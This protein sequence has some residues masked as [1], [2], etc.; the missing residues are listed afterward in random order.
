[1]SIFKIDGATVKDPK[2]FGWQP[3]T[4][5]GMNHIQQPVYATYRTA[6]ASFNTLT[7]AEFNA[8]MAADDSAYHSVTI[9]NSSGSAAVTYTNVIILRQGGDYGPKGLIYNASFTIERLVGP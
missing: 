7:A 4:P 8:W 5:I 3:P 1:M 6:H 9:P 2:S